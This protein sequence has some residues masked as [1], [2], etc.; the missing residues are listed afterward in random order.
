MPTTAT[1]SFAT[2]PTAFYEARGRVDGYDLDDWLRAEAQ[3]VEA[4]GERA[5]GAARLS[6]EP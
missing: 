1:P 3:A 6:S 2:P 4:F 5:D